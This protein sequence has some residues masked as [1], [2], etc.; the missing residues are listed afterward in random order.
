MAISKWVN[1]LINLKWSEKLPVTTLISTSALHTFSDLFHFFRFFH[2]EIVPHLRTKWNWLHVLGWYAEE[3]RTANP[4]VRTWC[5]AMAEKVSEFADSGSNHSLQHFQ[6]WIIS[7]KIRVFVTLCLHKA[8]WATMYIFQCY[9]SVRVNT[10]LFFCLLFSCF[11]ADICVKQSFYM[12]IFGVFFHQISEL[13]RWLNGSFPMC[14]PIKRAR[15]ISR[16][17]S[18]LLMLLHWNSTTIGWSKSRFRWV[19]KTILKW[20]NL[21]F[22]L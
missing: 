18:K 3:Q 21:N 17:I 7:A 19:K 13:W 12:N 20:L 11:N 2:S 16:V 5:T 4:I 6:F 10:F 9:S 1:L 8:D 22:K 14:W 15:R